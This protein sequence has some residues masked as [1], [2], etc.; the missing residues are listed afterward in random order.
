M[1]ESHHRNKEPG[2]ESSTRIQPDDQGDEDRLNIYI[3]KRSEVDSDEESRFPEVI[4]QFGACLGLR[5]RACRTATNRGQLSLQDCQ[6]VAI[7]QDVRELASGFE[8]TAEV[9]RDFAKSNEPNLADQFNLKLSQTIDTVDATT[10]L[11]RPAVGWLVSKH[12]SRRAWD[13][14]LCSDGLNL[15]L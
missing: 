1:G 7:K 5:S 3:Q 11:G 8:T 9:Q 2:K 10:G 15:I 12:S 13:L 14:S 6:G 4:D